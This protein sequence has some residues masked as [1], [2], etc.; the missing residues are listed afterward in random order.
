MLPAFH[1]HR[2]ITWNAHVD[3]S[4]KDASR[5]DMIVGRDL[6]HELDMDILFSRASMVWDNAE[7]LMQDPDWLDTANIKQFEQE[8]FMAHDPTT[9]DAARI[10]RILDTKY[11]KADLTEVVEELHHLTAE[12]QKHLLKLLRKV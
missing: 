12:Q 7:V 6:M 1:K 10:Q 4:P 3:E 11:S 8:M 2:D 9:T 5:Y